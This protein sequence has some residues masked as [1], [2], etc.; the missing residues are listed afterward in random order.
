MVRFNAVTE[1]NIVQCVLS[2][3]IEDTR[4]MDNMNQLDV[5]MTVHGQEHSKHVQVSIIMTQFYDI[6]CDDMKIYDVNFS[7]VTCDTSY[8][9]VDYGK[10]KATDSNYYR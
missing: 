3:V 1:I 5:S 2:I 9:E 8:L 7:G 4:W 6:I 10:V